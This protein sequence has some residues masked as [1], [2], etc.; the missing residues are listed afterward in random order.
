MHDQ[1]EDVGPCV[2]TRNIEL[3]PRTHELFLTNVR[4]QNG[5]E[6]VRRSGDDFPVGI[7]DDAASRVDPALDAREVLGLEGQ[8]VRNIVLADG[9]AAPITTARPSLAA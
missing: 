8:I 9:L 2:M 1:F 5:L 3:P 7:D 4:I 6:F